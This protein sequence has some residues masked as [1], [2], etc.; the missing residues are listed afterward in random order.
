ML[1]I[2]I[3]FLKSY[4]IVLMVILTIYA[5]RHYFFTLNRLFAEQRLYYQDIID[6]E[7]PKVSVLIPMH[8]EEKVANLVLNSII[9]V[10]YPEDK[11]EIIPINDHS[12]DKTKDI[13][14]K[15]SKNY[16]QI[17]P[18]HIYDNKT[19]GKQN[20]I[21]KAV[22]IATGEIIVIYD[23]DYII[24]KGQIRDL[25]T[26]FIDPSVGAVMGKV[27]PF[28]ANKNLLTLFLTMERSA[29]YQI[30]QQARY[31]LD[32]IPQ[33]GGTVAAFRRDLF[34]ELGKFD[35][36]ILAED[37][38]LTFKLYINGYKV[39]YANRLE[40]YEEVPETWEAR[41]KQ[42][43]RWSRGHN[44]VMFKYFFKLILTDK[45]KFYQKLEGILLLMIYLVPFL[46]LLGFIDSI[47]LFFLGEMQIV[48]YYLFL[49]AVFG[50]NVFGN[51]A[52][53]YQIAMANFL[54]N[55][56]DYLKILPLFFISFVFNLFYSSL[57]FIDSVLD[58]ITKRQI[59]WDK[60]ERFFQ[61]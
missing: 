16:P 24:P 11:I 27:I 10:Y 47:I 50:Y 52:P 59:K 49:L 26:F 51:F 20:I 33:Y 7:L 44:Q 39:A 54:E 57:G 36:N 56:S 60:T 29:G 43:R 46:T 31:N 21:N 23:A 1:E 25:V 61:K 35:S 17:K 18:L 38:E 4:L 2:L 3:F 45:L 15:H 30:D 34:I 40:A 8:N 32:L 41:A 12:T 6:S 13:L 58:L 28:N 53:F 55:N 22:D 9:N 37:T 19:K 48:N 42:L 14:E 5:I